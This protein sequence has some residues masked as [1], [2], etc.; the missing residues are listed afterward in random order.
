MREALMLVPRMPVD[1]ESRIVRLRPYTDDEDLLLRVNAGITE[2]RRRLG[3][4]LATCLR[5]GRDERK[6][7][8]EYGREF[9]GQCVN[10]PW[11]AWGG[12][13]AASDEWS[14]G[15]IIE[16]QSR[17]KTGGFTI[18][19]RDDERLDDEQFDDMTL[20]WEQLL[21]ERLCHQST[22]DFA[23]LLPRRSALDRRVHH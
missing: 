22:R 2:P 4:K 14:T 23:E 20:P 10:V 13:Y 7:S 3:K 1:V 5:V 16:Y 17:T 6:R 8:A 18:R 12:E 9:L 15:K 21:G 11:S 19:F